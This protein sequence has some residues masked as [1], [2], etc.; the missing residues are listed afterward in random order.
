M[1]FNKSLRFVF[2]ALIISGSS[3]KRDDFE[4]LPV[5]ETLSVTS[6]TDTSAMSGG[7]I[8]DDGG[9]GIAGKG[10]CWGINPLPVITDNRIFNGTGNGD[11]ISTM[12]FLRPNTTY[13][14]R[15]YAT[16]SVG[17]GYGNVVNF[18]TN[19]SNAIIE[20]NTENINPGLNLQQ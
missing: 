15:A 3:C 16:N 9:R 18:T 1:N 5:V 6:I 4:Q 20:I 7:K 13:N 10:I 8:I 19:D 2:I 17:T 11:F 12:N 14:V